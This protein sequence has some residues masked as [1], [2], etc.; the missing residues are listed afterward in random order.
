M[1]APTTYGEFKGVL[2]EKIFKISQKIFLLSISRLQIPLI[3]FII[4]NYP[5]LQIR[6]KKENLAYSQSS[7]CLLLLYS[8]N[9]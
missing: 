5:N 6:T 3:P 1:Y 2:H 9:I 4:C 8:G 7:Q